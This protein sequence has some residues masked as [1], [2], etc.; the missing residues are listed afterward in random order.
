[1]GVSEK[2]GMSYAKFWSDD[3]DMDLLKIYPNVVAECLGTLAD[4]QLWTLG[5]ESYG[6]LNH[7]TVWNTHGAYVWVEKPNLVRDP[8]GW[9]AVRGC[10]DDSP[11]IE[12]TW[13]ELLRDW[14]KWPCA[15]LKTPAR[16]QRRLLRTR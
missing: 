16:E 7:P 12:C 9:Y 8:R 3:F 6:R 2:V 10:V 5:H 11:E 4:R 15:S 13:L 1:V 14:T